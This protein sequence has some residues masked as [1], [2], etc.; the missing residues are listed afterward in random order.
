MKILTN[1]SFQKKLRKYIRPILSLSLILILMFMS[2]GISQAFS[3][4]D[5]QSIHNGTPFYDPASSGQTSGLCSAAGSGTIVAGTG[6]PDGASFP[7]LN[8][9]SMVTAINSYIKNYNPTSEL[10]GLGS[11]IV[12][13]GYNS[14][15]NPFLIVAIAQKETGLAN[16]ASYNVEYANNAFSREATSTQPNYPGA[17]ININTLWYKW[18]STANET[19]VKASVDYTAPQNIG[20]EGGG[21]VASYLRARYG[22]QI[23]ANNIVGIFEVYAPPGDNNT[24]QYIAEINSWVS[25]LVSL[26]TNS[27]SNVTPYT[28]PNAPTVSTSTNCGSVDCSSSTNS[29]LSQTRQNVV[30]LAKQQLAIWE[31][32]PGYP[33]Q[34][35]NTYSGT[36]YLIYSQQSVEQWCADFVS[37]VY[38]QAGYP[39]TPDPGWRNAAVAEIQAIGEENNNF[40]WHNIS[41]PSGADY[42]PTYTPVPG[43][44]SIFGIGHTNIVVSVAGSVVTEIGGDQGNGPYPGGSIVSEVTG[45]GP[46]GYV[47]PD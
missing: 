39:L 35:T 31:S 46:T 38:D 19:G 10:N 12:A 15:V 34:G 8:P 1:Y 7:D 47:S 22:S 23:D 11:T 45:G 18:T 37:W 44:I 26:T 36:G 25:E 3:E 27:G 20:A 32:Q 43:D 41:D 2:T 42:D 24:A 16:P 21:D 17:G 29:S 40:H 30:C 14:N 13:D 33:W 9:A 4:S 5:V 28:L 6:L